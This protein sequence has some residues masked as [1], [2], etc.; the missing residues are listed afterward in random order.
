[1]STKNR[2]IGISNAIESTPNTSPNTNVHTE[3]SEAPNLALFAPIPILAASILH[4]CGDVF[5]ATRA[6]LARAVLFESGAEL[7]IQAPAHVPEY[8]R[9]YVLPLL[10]ECLVPRK[11]FEVEVREEDYCSSALIHKRRRRL[12]K[13]SM[14]E[15]GTYAW[16][17]EGVVVSETKFDWVEL[18]AEKVKT[19]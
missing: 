11:S 10:R 13:K 1:M 2:K 16:K 3:T 15:A 5:V 8:P 18:E 12:C 7:I 6:F 14:V 9:T 4:S 19:S 17:F